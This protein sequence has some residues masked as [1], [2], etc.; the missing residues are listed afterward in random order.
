MIRATSGDEWPVE[1]VQLSAT[2]FGE[3]WV[4]R[5]P[6]KDSAYMLDVIAQQVIDQKVPAIIAGTLMD[7][8]VG[9]MDC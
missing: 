2:A 3:T 5:Y 6:L 8:V 4:Y 1:H 7:A 9:G